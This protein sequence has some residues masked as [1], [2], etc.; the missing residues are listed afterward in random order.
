MAWR[1]MLEK[2][3]IDQGFQIEWIWMGRDA[4]FLLAWKGRVLAVHFVEPDESAGPEEPMAVKELFLEL[5]SHLRRLESW[6]R[7]F[8]GREVLFKWL[9]FRSFSDRQIEVLKEAGVDPFI[10]QPDDGFSSN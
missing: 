3:F 8:K 10:C 5:F 7:I 1:D 2:R 4:L 6:D 9:S